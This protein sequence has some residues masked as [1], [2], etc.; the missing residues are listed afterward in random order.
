MWSG[1]ILENWFHY[2]THHCNVTRIQIRKTDYITWH[3]TVMR[4]GPILGKPIPLCVKA[5]HIHNTSIFL[6]SGTYLQTNCTHSHMWNNVDHFLLLLTRLLQTFRPRENTRHFNW[7]KLQIKYICF[8]V[9]IDYTWLT[10]WS[11]Q[12][13]ASQHQTFCLLQKET[14]FSAYLFEKFYF[15]SAK[16]SPMR[17]LIA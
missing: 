5:N 17:G 14:L 11:L 15:D 8:F 2:V 6:S 13:Y 3:I 12:R 10:L 4:S 1:Y 16:V 7:S 9:V